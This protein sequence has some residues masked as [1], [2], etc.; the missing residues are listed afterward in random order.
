MRR[1]GGLVHSVQEAGSGGTDRLVRIIGTDLKA[2]D[3]YRPL[4]NL[5]YENSSYGDTGGDLIH[6]P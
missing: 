1:A 5:S 2:D 4:T 6:M 3:A